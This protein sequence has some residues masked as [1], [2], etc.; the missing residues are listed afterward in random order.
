[1]GLFIYDSTQIKSNEYATFT[2]V[3][4]ANEGVAR[5]SI[6]TVD[7]KGADKLKIKSASGNGSSVTAKWQSNDGCQFNSECTIQCS[8]STDC[9]KTDSQEY[10]VL[11]GGVCIYYEYYRNSGHVL[12]F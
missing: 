12:A 5:E 4:I 2:C 3:G 6:L 7:C 1:M 11:K 10:Q 8:A 9:K